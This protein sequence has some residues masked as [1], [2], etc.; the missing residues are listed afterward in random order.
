M[1]RI[2]SGDVSWVFQ[3]DKVVEHVT[4]ISRL[5]LPHPKKVLT[6]KIKVMT[7][8]IAFF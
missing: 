2:I 6:S 7:M 4:R 3:C 1:N 5:A 8:F